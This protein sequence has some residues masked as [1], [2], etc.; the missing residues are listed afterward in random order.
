MVFTSIIS[1]LPA[2]FIGQA[3]SAATTTSGADNTIHVY[4]G[5]GNNPTEIAATTDSK[6]NSQFYSC[7]YIQNP[8]GIFDIAVNRRFSRSFNYLTQAQNKMLTGSGIVSG[9]YRP[10]S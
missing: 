1:F 5:S 2:E 10:K 6:T 9:I 4:D 7:N 3:A 8:S